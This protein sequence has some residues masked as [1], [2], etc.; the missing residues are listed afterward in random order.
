MSWQDQTYSSGKIAIEAIPGAAYGFSN[1]GGGTP[2]T[3]VASAVTT[4]SIGASAAGVNAGQ[5]VTYSAT[6]NPAPGGGTIA[7]AD[8]G[9]AI[10]GCGAQPVNANGKA[11]CTV[12]YTAIGTH[13][14]T[15]LYTGS[16]DGEFVGSTNGPD[17][18]VRVFSPT[19]A[20]LVATNTNLSLSSATPATHTA[21]RF[22]ATVN[23]APDG[24]TVSFTDGDGNI[25]G[26]TSQPV[27]KGASTCKVTYGASGIHQIR[28]VYTGDA[29]FGASDSSTAPMTVSK[30]P[31]LRVAKR[32]LIV[33]T[34][35]PT[36]S[37]G[38]RLT[39]TIAVTPQGVK[40]AINLKRLS[41]KLKAGKTRRFTFGLSPRERATLR[42]DLRQHHS[43]HLGITVRVGV[44]DGNG[45]KGTQTFSFK[46]SGAQA[47][48]LLA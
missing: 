24:G 28:A 8:G 16:P 39:S 38:C 3:P 7:F 42:S 23:P 30:R 48:S 1:F 12:T 26:C 43:T 14:V 31:S 17:A 13:V 25:R 11:T 10:P 35:C 29:H 45:S 19:S 15:A 2:A 36:H 21:V 47:Q 41:A 5:Q 4:T 9:V 46:V 37:G 22:T 27:T 18:I 20:K 40:K 34:A 6:V 32:S 44:R 33:T